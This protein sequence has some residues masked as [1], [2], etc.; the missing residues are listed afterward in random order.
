MKKFESIIGY[1][2]EKE[3]FETMSERLVEVFRKELGNEKLDV[4]VEKLKND[5][6]AAM[7]T[8][9]E[10]SRRMQEMMKMYGMMGMDPG[11]LG[12]EGTLVLNVNHAL[13]KYVADH[14]E[15]DNNGKRT[16]DSQI[17]TK[18][19]NSGLCLEEYLGAA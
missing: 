17:A 5:N 1:E 4:K 18:I 9:S 10:E 13:V 15:S 7:M 19:Y 11:M 6:V 3:A 2:T 16:K 14:K 12:S 8:L